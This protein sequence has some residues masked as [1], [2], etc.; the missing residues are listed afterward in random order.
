MGIPYTII[1]I[2]PPT[3]TKPKEETTMPDN[4]T[5]LITELSETETDFYV[6]LVPS[7]LKE[8]SISRKLIQT[9]KLEH[10]TTKATLEKCY[11][12]YQTELS[13]NYLQS[14]EVKFWKTTTVVLSLVIITFIYLGSI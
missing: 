13:K 4:T 3:I 6:K 2:L 10:N 8:L 1:P 9:S 11:K 14:K 7:L 5:K 12:D